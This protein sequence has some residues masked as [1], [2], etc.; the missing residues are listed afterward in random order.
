MKYARVLLENC[1]PE[2]TQLFV[3]YF[4][5]RYQQKKEAVIQ[6]VVEQQP[7]YAAGAVNAVQNLKDLLP[8]PYMNPS[9]VSSPAT[10]GNITGTVSDNQLVEN[11]NQISARSYTP[12]Q[13]RTAFSSLWITQTSSSSSWR[14]V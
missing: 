9:A 8:L 3:D 14:H 5:G 11:T 7:G 10:Q 13:P 6:Q 2:T 4:T 1:P 12:P